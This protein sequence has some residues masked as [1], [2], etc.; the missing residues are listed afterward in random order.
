MAKLY[1]LLRLNKVDGVFGVEIEC[2]GQNLYPIITK[3]WDSKA[4][5]SLRGV[6]PNSAVEWVFKKPLPYNE[7]IRALNALVKAQKDNNAAP[8]FSFRTSTHVHFN[9]QEATMDQ[10]CAVIYT[11]CLI[12]E[13]LVNFAGP[14][15]KANRFCLSINDGEGIL[16]H[17]QHIFQLGDAALRVNENDVRYA[18]LNIASLRKYGSLEVRLLR[19]TLDL[20]V[21]IPWIT[22]IGSLRDFGMRMESPRKVHDLF[23]KIGPDGLIKEVFPETHQELEYKGWQ[24]DVNR[25]FSITLDLVF[26]FVSEEERMKKKEDENKARAQINIEA[27]LAAIDAEHRM[28]GVRFDRVIIDEVAQ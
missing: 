10:L 24:D 4:D 20:D 9:M 16:D 21:L 1:E 5:G 13:L 22:S 19:G 11:Y 25:N 18:A 6:F 3:G 17:Y 27:A 8:S 12:E 7:T 2:E 14:S 15:R 28:R 23:A 26:S